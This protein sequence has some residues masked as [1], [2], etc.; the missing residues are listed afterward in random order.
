MLQERKY[1]CQADLELLAVAVGV[2]QEC[3]ASAG[4][5]EAGDEC[6]ESS[7]A[8]RCVDA[9]KELFVIV[10]YPECVRARLSTVLCLVE[11]VAIAIDVAAL[12]SDGNLDMSRGI[13][14][15]FAH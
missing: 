7:D 13:E 8:L 11:V 10:E 5:C 3:P 6:S 12:R 15:R 9:V 2:S 1:L 14:G 4:D